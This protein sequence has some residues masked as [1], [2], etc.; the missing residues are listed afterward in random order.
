MGVEIPVSVDGSGSSG[1]NHPLESDVDKLDD[2]VLYS[3]GYPTISSEKQAFVAVMGDSTEDIINIIT[4]D[5]TIGKRSILSNAETI[6]SY[7]KID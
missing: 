2:L 4:G 3:G 1:N 5:K 6:T 7:V